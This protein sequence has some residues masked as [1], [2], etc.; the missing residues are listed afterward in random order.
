[1]STTDGSFS[2]RHGDYDSHSAT[3]LAMTRQIRS[4]LDQLQGLLVNLM[5]GEGWD[6]SAKHAYSLA[7]QSWNQACDEMSASLGQAHEV[8][9]DIHD[10]Y[11]ITDARGASRFHR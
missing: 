8:S 9:Q 6:G 7:Q 2:L 4:C 11:K 5:N 1:V 3:L 10:N